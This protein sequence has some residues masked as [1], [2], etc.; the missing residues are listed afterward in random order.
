MESCKK[1]NTGNDFMYE[2]SVIL[3]NVEAVEKML[4]V[5]SSDLIFDN[6]TSETLK[7]AAEMFMYLNSCS[8]DLIPLVK[9]FKDL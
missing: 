4:N 5:T 6:M 9:F 1:S 3:S 7:T 8:F 2:D